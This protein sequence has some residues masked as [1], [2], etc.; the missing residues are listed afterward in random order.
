[1]D[2]FFLL[3][4]I[5]KQRLE[6]IEKHDEKSWEIACEN[7]HKNRRKELEEEPFKRENE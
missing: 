4:P 2:N 3:P 6:D 1:M 5:V 7:H